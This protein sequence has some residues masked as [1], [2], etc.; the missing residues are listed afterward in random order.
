MLGGKNYIAN[1][2]NLWREAHKDTKHSD[3]LN[4]ADQFCASC[5]CIILH[6]EEP[7][8]LATEEFPIACLPVGHQPLIAHQIDYLEANGLHAIIV[9]VHEKSFD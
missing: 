7:Q 4:F 2:A 1:M 3:P 5:S 8:G 6:Q 9:V